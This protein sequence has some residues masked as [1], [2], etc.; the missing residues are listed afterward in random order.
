MTDP[1]GSRWA[2][3]WPLFARRPKAFCLAAGALSALAFVPVG[4]FPLYW[5]A[6]P[7][8]V[9]ALTLAPT[10]R[11]AALR[12]WLFGLGH[13]VV[14]LY[15]IGFAPMVDA[16]RFW[17]VV[18]FAMLGLP[19]G[20]ALFSALGAIA[21]WLALRLF[22]FPV[23]IG[24]AIFWSLGEWL[25]STILTGFPWNLSGY[26]WN[27]VLAML[28]GV[29]WVGVHGLGAL[30]VLAAC[31]PALL[32]LS[33]QRLPVPRGGIVLA[34]LSHLALLIIAGIGAARLELPV[35][36]GTTLV[37]IVQPNIPQGQKWDPDMLRIHFERHLAL[38]NRPGIEDVDAVIWPE[39]AANFNLERSDA[40]RREIAAILPAGSTL[41]TG[42][43]RFANEEVFNSL[44]VIDST[45]AIIASYDKHHLVPFGE[46]MPLR[47]FLPL[48]PIAA[49][50]SD[51]SRGPGPRTVQVGTL[52]PFSPLICYE[53]IFP[54]RTVDPGNRPAW[55]VN[56]T[57]DAW[58][59]DTSGPRQHFAIARVRAIEQ[60]IPLVR[61]ANTGISGFVDPY[62][63]LIA[64]VA[65][66]V[67][68]IA[69]LA[70]PRPAS[71]PFLNPT[72]KLI[73]FLLILLF[74]ALSGMSA[75]QK[76]PVI[77]TGD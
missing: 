31:S 39:T 62:G 26:V 42:T 70:L 75:R 58:Y 48:E 11:S 64:T 33:R 67:T 71:P 45:G 12:G 54:S 5:V 34:G 52:P 66:A 27:D 13:F 7:V 21:A 57:N 53:A 76:H 36:P 61:S 77:L 37:R 9:L 30:T 28:Q 51:F 44:A 32:L 20:L 60:G 69:D 47:D 40:A 50:A 49:G 29:R 16:G 19:A 18:P 17:W 55:L 24:L 1:A 74:S 46:Y 4:L 63:R 65:F 6:F 43:L 3:L 8:L 72:G 41:L 14:G 38:T 22:R 73:I 25:R 10:W 59:G 68:G 56:V 15:W 2:R 35:L 23:W